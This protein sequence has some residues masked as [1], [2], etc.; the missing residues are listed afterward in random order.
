M[1]GTTPAARPSF[2]MGRYL[3]SRGFHARH[4]TL[5]L[6]TSF[7]KQQRRIA[8]RRALLQRKLDFLLSSF[9][10]G[11]GT[12]IPP[13]P[14]VGVNP[15]RH[16]RVLC[17]SP[18][19]YSMLDPP[20]PKSLLIACSARWISLLLTF[21]LS[22]RMNDTPQSSPRPGR[23]RHLQSSSTLPASHSLSRP[24]PCQH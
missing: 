19:L 23:C 9:Q 20:C 16:H 11:P 4:E 6:G 1:D 22:Q 3:R 5:G 18:A 17:Q 24:Q 13:A 14:A 15:A 10:A 12:D 7:S 21:K 8:R 2:M